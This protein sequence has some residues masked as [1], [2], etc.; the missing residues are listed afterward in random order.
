MSIQERLR[1][2]QLIDQMENKKELCK[3]LG[4]ENESTFHGKPIDEYIGN[5][6]NGEK[7]ND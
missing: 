1:M 6:R 3:R 7:T 4:L 5:K 2:C